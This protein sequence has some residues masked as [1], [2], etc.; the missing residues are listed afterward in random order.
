MAKLTLVLAVQVYVPPLLLITLSMMYIEE[1]IVLP[2]GN[3][4]VT[5][6]SVGFE[7]ATVQLITRRCPTVSG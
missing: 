3:V 4:I 2:L 7:S 1:F 6:Y 5:L